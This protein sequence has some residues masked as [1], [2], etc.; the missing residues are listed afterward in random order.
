M[1]SETNSSVELI[2]QRGHQNQGRYGSVKKK[3][4]EI[5]WENYENNLILSSCN[6]NTLKAII[7]DILIFSCLMVIRLGAGINVP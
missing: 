7:S 2:K 3:T 5:V 1:K 6:N 4:L